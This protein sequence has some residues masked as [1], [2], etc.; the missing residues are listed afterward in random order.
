MQPFG[1]H[2]DTILVPLW[3]IVGPPGTILGQILKSWPQILK[4]WLQIL[5][6]CPQIL[7]SWLACWPFW[8]CHGLSRRSQTASL[9]FCSPILCQNGAG[10]GVNIVM[11]SEVKI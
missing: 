10:E 6:S 1:A 3:T 5:K 11:F 9:A 8:V 4:S 2:F 7:T